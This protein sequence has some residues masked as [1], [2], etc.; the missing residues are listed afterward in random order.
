MVA[1]VILINSVAALMEFQFNKDHMDM[2]V[3]AHKLNIN[4][5]QMASQRLLEKTLPDVHVQQVNTVVVLM[6]LLMLKDHTL[7]V[8]LIFHQHHKRHVASIKMVAL[9]VITRLNTSLIWNMVVAHV[10]GTADAVVI[11][12][13]LKQLTNAKALVN[14]QLAK[15]HAK[16]QRFTD[17][18]LD[19]IKNTTMIQIVIFAHHSFMVVA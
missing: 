7:M 5:V 4:V 17:H 8:A 3:I 11:Q 15:M 1:L 16:F 12:I 6:E 10:S 2:D 18:V 9:A 14:N 13:V 19:I